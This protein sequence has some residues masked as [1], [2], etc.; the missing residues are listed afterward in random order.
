V[1]T[2]RRLALAAG[3]VGGAIAVVG[4]IVVR[5]DA[6]NIYDGLTSGAG[7]LAV[8]GSALAGLATLAAILLG[9][10]EFARYSAAVAVGAIVAGWAL[11]QSPDLL[12][13]LSVDEAAAGDATLVALLIATAVGAL[14]LIPSLTLLFG[15]VLRGAFDPREPGSVE[16]ATAVEEAL[17]PTPGGRAAPSPVL[18]RAAIACAVLGLPLTVIPDGGAVLA[19]GVVL[20]LAAVGLGS[21]ALIPAVAID[22]GSEPGR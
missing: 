7:L 8:I 10:F 13:G 17:A 6:R 5:D 12:P 3:A 16:A 20:L 1:G 4:L 9:R 15:L 22:D 21:A 18:G 19:I 14:I 2:F 11:A